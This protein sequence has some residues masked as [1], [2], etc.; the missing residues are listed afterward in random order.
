MPA[1]MQAKLLRAIESRTVRPVGSDIE[2]PIDVRFLAATNRDLETDA[3]EGRF[4]RDLFFRINVIQVPVPP[5]RARGTMC[6]C[7]RR[8]FWSGRP[9]APTRRCQ[10]LAYVARATTDRLQQHHYLASL[11]HHLFGPTAHSRDFFIR[12]IQTAIGVKISDYTL[13]RFAYLTLDRIHMELP[14]QMIG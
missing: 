4:R 2:V 5:L 10:T 7:W 9:R 12:R 11:F 14:F 1:A 6:C 8:S 13:R 3:E